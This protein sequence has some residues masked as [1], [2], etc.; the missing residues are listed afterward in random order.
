MVV[1]IFKYL[2]YVQFCT[3]N[4]VHTAWH[5]FLLRIFDCL[6][7]AHFQLQKSP[8]PP[9]CTSSKKMPLSNCR[10][11]YSYPITPFNPCITT[12]QCC[13]ADIFLGV[14][15]SV[16]PRGPRADCGSRQKRGGSG[17]SFDLCLRKQIT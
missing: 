6:N 7:P 13:G 15:G 14:S 11:E 12:M 5:G 1:V 2:A 8:R 4:R 16:R 17:A 3:N 9:F 10:T